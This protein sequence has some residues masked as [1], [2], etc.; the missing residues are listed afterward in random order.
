[1][2][3][4]IKVV[5]M[6]HAVLILYDKSYKSSFVFINSKPAI[7]LLQIKTGLFFSEVKSLKGIG[8]STISP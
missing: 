1:M 3:V 4:R 8:I 7:H 5:G 6:R 2:M